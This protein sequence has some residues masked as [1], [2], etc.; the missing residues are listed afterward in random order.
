MNSDSLC[1]T[2]RG[3]VCTSDI[4]LYVNLC[5]VLA[6]LVTGRFILRNPW[7]LLCAAVV[8]VDVDDDGGDDDDDVDG[9]DSEKGDKN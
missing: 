8:D 3:I 2:Y 6:L 1:F 7:S 5:L 9:D 4:T